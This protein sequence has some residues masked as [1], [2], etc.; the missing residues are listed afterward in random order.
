MHETSTSQSTLARVSGVRQPSISQFLAGRTPMSDAMLERLLECMGYSLEIVR[1]PVR[2]DLGRQQRRSWLL[3]RRLVE[4]LDAAAFGD[5]A[6][7]MRRNLQ[8]LRQQTQ[9]E[10]H[11]TNLDRWETLIDQADLNGLRRAMCGLDDDSQAM[12]EVSPMGGL[13]PQAERARV[14]AGMTS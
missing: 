14:L 1:R 5:W 7:R 2:V 13:L 10:P 8:Q 3:H 11:L 9:G 4:R 12:R 6:P